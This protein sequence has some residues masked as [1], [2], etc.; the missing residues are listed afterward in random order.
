[1]DPATIMGIASLL[2]QAAPMV[3]NMFG[4][5]D[6]G[7]GNGGQGGMDQYDTGTQSPFAEFFAGNPERVAHIPQFTQQQSPLFQILGEQG[8]QQYMNPY[9]GFD[10]IAN[11]AQQNFRQNTLPSL[12]ERFTSMGKNSMTSPL[13]MSQMHNAG[14][15]LDTQ[16]A[17]MKQMYGMKNRSQGLEAL[18]MALTP[19]YQNIRLGAQPGAMAGI[20]PEL[21]KFGGNLGLEYAKSQWNNPTPAGAE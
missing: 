19:Q 16:L 8:K 17:S 21:M 11:Q 6:K 12:A 4:G 10:A 15:G 13:F 18:A 14:A 9:Q 3:Y 1:M 20:M 2:M 7:Q 5:S